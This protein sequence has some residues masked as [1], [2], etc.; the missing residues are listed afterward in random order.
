MLFKT[1]LIELP[2]WPE[3]D[4]EPLDSLHGSRRDS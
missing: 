4:S 3:A 1:E 2:L